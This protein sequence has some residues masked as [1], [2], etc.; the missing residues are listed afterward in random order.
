MRRSAVIA[1][2]AVTLAACGGASAKTASFAT[3]VEAQ[4]AIDKGWMPAGLPQASYEIRA[5][6]VPNGW[7]RWGIINFPASAVPELRALLEPQELSLAG[8]RCVVPGRIEWWPVQLREQLDAERIAATGA[9][10][11]RARAGKLI[12]VVN[13]TQGRGYYWATE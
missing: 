2:A 11:Y 12:F 4:P 6:Y 9:R 7:Q 8:V 10:A 3:L 13:W 1:L 5:A